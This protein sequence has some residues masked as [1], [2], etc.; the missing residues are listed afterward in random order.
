MN[1]SAAA[2]VGALFPHTGRAY[3]VGITGVPGGGKSTLVDQLIATVRAAGQ[4]V[5]VLAVDPTSPFS[6]GAILGDRVRMQRHATDPGVFIR[7]MASRGELGGLAR[8]TYDAALVMD[9]MGYDPVIIET[10]GVGQD[11]VEIATLAH[12]T[13]VVSV[14]GLGDEI[15]AIKAGVLETGQVFV[16]NKADRP[17]TD[18]LQRQLELMLHLRAQS[19]TEGDWSPPLLATVASRGEG[20]ATLLDAV[21]AHAAHLKSV[22]RHAQRL[23]ERSRR[24]LLAEFGA[25]SAARLLEAGRSEPAIAAILD[26]VSAGHLDPYTAVAALHVQVSAE[27]KPESAC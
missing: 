2:L 26:A 22:G 5:A 1:D 15:Q 4:R 6:G 8:A 23:G 9:A 18:E 24:V 25:A 20:V 7:S 10:V 17:G 16:I 11:E 19:R 27:P 21:L 14:P 13:V 12:T 3:H